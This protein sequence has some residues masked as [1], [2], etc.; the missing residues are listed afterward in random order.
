MKNELIPFK[1]ENHE[2][3]TLM[4]DDQPYWVGRDVAVV[5]G[6]KNAPHAINTHCKG[7]AKWAPL[8]TDGG[9]QKMRVITE[10]DVWRLVT[11]CT[12]PE[13]QRFEAWLYNVLLPEIYRTGALVPEGME[14][15]NKSVFDAMSAENE[16]FRQLLP[17]IEA[18]VESVQEGRKLRDENERLER[19]YQ[20]SP[21]D[22]R[23]VLYLHEAGYNVSQ[24]MGKTKKG[25]TRIKRVIEEAAAASQPGLFDDEAMVAASR[26]KGE[27]V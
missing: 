10:G 12:L 6:Y 17:R 16:H 27:A 24:I 4:I 23:E 8:L 26:G 25:R 3:R 18:L 19:R 2:V 22:K 7:V 13:A 20:F 9:K 21:D 1:F 14:L 11:N 15:V 5:L